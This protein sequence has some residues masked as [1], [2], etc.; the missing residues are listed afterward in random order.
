MTGFDPQASGTRPWEPHGQNQYPEEALVR[1]I[2]QRI[3]HCG[4]R[5]LESRLDRFPQ[6]SLSRQCLQQCLGL[7]E[8]GG[9]K[10]FGEP[11]IDRRQQL[12]GFVDLILLLP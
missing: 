1:D 12:A 8:V 2:L 11:A 6:C 4:H 3:E 9:V 7:L 10:A 5:F